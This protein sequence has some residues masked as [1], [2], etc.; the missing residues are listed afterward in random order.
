M[1]LAL[2]LPRSHLKQ[3]ICIGLLQVSQHAA[4][5]C[6]KVEIE[7]RVLSYALGIHLIADQSQG[8]LQVQPAARADLFPSL[9][10]LGLRQL[11]SQYVLGPLRGLLSP[12][13]ESL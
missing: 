13:N 12:G 7:V 8:D 5:I 10:I 3:V 4:L 2:L 9:C 11:E 1:A 6:Y